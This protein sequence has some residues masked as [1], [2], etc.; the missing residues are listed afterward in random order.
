MDSRLFMVLL[1]LQALISSPGIVCE[2]DEFITSEGLSW[3]DDFE[4]GNFDD[5]LTYGGKL[6]G[7]KLPSNFTIIDGAL[8]GQGPDW[9]LAFYDSEVVTGT[10]SMDI[11]VVGQERELLVCFMLENH[12]HEILWKNA[13]IIEFYTQP[14]RHAGDD[15]ITFLRMISHEDP[16][17]Y[18]WLQFKRTGELNGWQHL[19]ITRDNYGQICVYLNSTLYINLRDNRITESTLFCFSGRAGH[20]I[21]NVN[22]TNNLITIDKAPP[23]WTHSSPSDVTIQL[24]E[25]LRYDLNATDTS[26]I[27]SYWVNDT[28][29]FDIDNQGI[30]TDKTSLD[31]GRYGI[32]VS[33][34][35]TNGYTLTSSFAVIVSEPESIPIPIEWIF[36]GIVGIVGVIAIVVVIRLRKG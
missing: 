25:H 24:N 35:D 11:Y 2:T 8:F 1:L 32:Q 36:I 3:A 15:V 26:G 33:V 5:W 4:D 18:D 29:N 9:N 30:I 21:D 27:D 17:D 34:N 12:T 20:G 19:D 23:L 16:A 22:I 6:G 10:W 14:N 28:V 13:Y 7:E 31:V